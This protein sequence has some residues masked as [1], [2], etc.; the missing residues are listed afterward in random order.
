MYLAG[1]AGVEDVGKGVQEAENCGE[2]GIVEMKE[3]LH[4]RE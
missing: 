2:D 4:G 3:L 1:G